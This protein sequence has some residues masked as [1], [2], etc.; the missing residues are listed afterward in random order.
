MNKSYPAIG[1]RSRNELAKRIAHQGFSQQEALALIEDCEL[2]HELYWKDSRRSEPSKGKYVRSAVGAPLGNLLK[3]IDRRVFA[4]NDALIPA[5]IYGGLNHREAISAGQALLG[6]RRNRRLIS[7]DIKTFFECI[8]EDRIVS[9]LRARCGCSDSVARLIAKLCTVPEGPKGAKGSRVLARGFAT[10]T[11][12]A[13]W[14]SINLLI[15]LYWHTKRK[16]HGK[17]PRLAIYI[18]DIGISASRVTEAE[19]QELIQS[20][21]LLLER[22]DF[23]LTLKIN[24]KKTRNA[25]HGQAQH[26]G[27]RLGRNKLAPGSKTAKKKSELVAQLKKDPNNR[28]ALKSLRSVQ[29]HIKRVRSRKSL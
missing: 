23:N 18:D 7:L 12:L 25:A 13:V 2:N 9:L 11:R 21:T 14:C 10:S 3:L 16:L 28:R 19:M 5:Y 24:E 1:I 22:H 17:D 26:L 20:V 15:R 27:M 4:P 6:K 8:R 29:G